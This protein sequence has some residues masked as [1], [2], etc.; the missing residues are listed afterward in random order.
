MTAKA[1]DAIT[2]KRSNRTVCERPLLLM[3]RTMERH[4]YA[5]SRYIYN[6]PICMQMAAYRTLLFRSQRSHVGESPG[7]RILS[8]FPVFLSSFHTRTHTHTLSEYTESFHAHTPGSR[9]QLRT[10]RDDGQKPRGMENASIVCVNVSQRNSTERPL[11][12]FAV[13]YVFSAI[14]RGRAYF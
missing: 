4:G 13:N 3:G 9:V 7:P 12:N 6:D 11:H 10:R 14:I 8:V 1:A 2:D 5:E